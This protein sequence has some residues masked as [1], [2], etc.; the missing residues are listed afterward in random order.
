MADSNLGHW[1]AIVSVAASTLVAIYT[2][3]E[4]SRTELA[5]E[6]IKA[7]YDNL[8][9]DKEHKW[10]GDL[11]RCSLIVSTAKNLAQSYSAVYQELDLSK[12]PEI[13]AHLWVAATIL[14][15]KNKKEFI[16]AYQNGA[17][18]GADDSISLTQNLVTIALQGLAIEG[19]DCIYTPP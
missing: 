15:P 10:T 3:S 19:Q 17:V 1:V 13:N 16:V 2:S 4:K 12:R 11:E 7:K 5:L 18:K 9:A 14:S 6:D 8:R